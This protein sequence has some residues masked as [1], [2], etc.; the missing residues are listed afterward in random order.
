M[1]GNGVKN[2]PILLVKKCIQLVRKNNSFYP[3]L[4]MRET[5]TKSASS[6]VISASRNGLEDPVTLLK[7]VLN[8]YTTATS[9][10]L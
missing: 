1:A 2:F 4:V 6:N 8:G 10:F 5:L 3:F 7:Y 9:G